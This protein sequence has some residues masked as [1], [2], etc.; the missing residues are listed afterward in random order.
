M[1]GASR[2]AARKAI[3]RLEE[4]GVLVEITGRGRL[5][6]WEATDLFA[7]LD[8]LEAGLRPG[9]ANLRIGRP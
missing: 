5:R 9:G 7:L 4:A 8:G 2:E 3:G 1:T 6:R